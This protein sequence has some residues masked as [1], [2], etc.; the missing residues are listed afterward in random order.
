MMNLPKAGKMPDYLN[1]PLVR[2]ICER[3]WEHPHKKA[4][5]EELDLRGKA[6]QRRQTLVNGPVS[7]LHSP[8]RR[9]SLTP[10]DSAKEPSDAASPNLTAIAARFAI[11]CSPTLS[12]SVTL[13]L[14]TL[15]PLACTTDTPTFCSWTA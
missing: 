14:T 1:R 13:G 11:V 6:A 9:V 3:S 12:D 2:R 10:M 15:S 5:R 4:S 8:P 7:L